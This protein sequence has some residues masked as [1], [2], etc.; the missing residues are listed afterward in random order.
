MYLLD[1]LERYQEEV[2]VRTR[3]RDFALTV[4]ALVLFV[5]WVVAWGFWMGVFPG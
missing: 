2:P 1:L 5:A 4:A 3:I